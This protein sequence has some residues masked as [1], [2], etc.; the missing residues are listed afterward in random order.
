[1]SK[2]AQQEPQESVDGE[3]NVENILTDEDI[4]DL[5][6]Q[7]SD[8]QSKVAEYWDQIIRANA[9]MENIKR[10]ATRDVESARKYSVESFAND[11]LPALDSLEQGAQAITEDTAASAMKEGM[12]LTISMLIKALEKQGMVQID[13]K[14]EKFDPEYH[15]AMTMIA[16]EEIP[17]DHVI[18]VFQKGYQLNG[19]VIR[20]ARVVVS[21]GNQEMPSIDTKA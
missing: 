14:G 13:P 18:D 21:N 8:A 17:G 5:K 11:I 2:D 9:E 1:M 15:E 4:A 12:E 10:R 20:P 7:L 6:E 16:S 19:R 3:E